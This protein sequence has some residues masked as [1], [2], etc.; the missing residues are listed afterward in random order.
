MGADIIQAKYEELESIA[1]CFGQWAD[2]NA[3]INARIQQAVDKLRRGDWI[4]KGSE[5]FFRKMDDEILPAMNRLT[6]A[7][8]Q[9]Q[10]VTREIIFIIQQAEEEAA[11]PFRN[12]ASENR[13]ARRTNAAAIDP[14]NPY[15]VRE[16]SSL[17]SNQYMGS[18]VGIK[19]QGEDTA[20][21]NSAMKVLFK[22]PT[23]AELDRVLNEIAVI[24]GVPPAIIRSQYQ[25]YLKLHE[26]ALAIAR[27]KGEE[28]PTSLNETFHG[29]FMGSTAQ[30]RY[31]KV[32][33]DAFGIDPVFGALLNPTGGMV[34][35]GNFAV[36]P[37]DDSA[38]GYHGIFHDAAG[39]L[40][41]YH[42]IGPGYN[43]L[44]Q[45]GQR[46]PSN[47]LVG[48][49][50]GVRYWTEKLYP[51]VVTDIALEVGDFVINTTEA[52]IET[53]RDIGDKIGDFVGDAYEDVKEVFD[54]IF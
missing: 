7:L 32:V 29:D 40:Y 2:N 4:G 6:T 18:F 14:A 50:S 34:G 36:N 48:Q 26:Q 30:L 43:Y 47:P 11:T 23:G 53:A 33:G 37:S 3:E 19:I 24:R 16:V 45:E 13:E 54:V 10:R 25:K 39:Y 41:N 49:Q 22:N 46:D 9:S 21:L 27:Q 35:P 15:I 38:L 5:A 52:G 12:G 28:A 42:N 20:R 31:G 44:G 8:E 17:F 1:S 51:G